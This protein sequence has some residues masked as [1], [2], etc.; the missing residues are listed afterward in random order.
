MTHAASGQDLF[1]HVTILENAM[2]GSPNIIDQLTSTDTDAIREGA[3]LAGGAGLKEAVPYLVGHIS[4]SNIGVQEAADRALR[5][6]GGSEVVLGVLP[7]LRSDDAPQR[8]IAMDILRGNG[9]ANLEA[10]TA[11]L[12]D[13]DA[14]IRIF[15]S[16]I[17]GSVASAEVVAPLG[18][19]LL[20]DPEVNVRYQ[21]AVSLGSL[22]SPEAATYLNKALK[23]D[24]WVQFSVI[25]ALTKIRAESSITAMIA[26]LDKS[27][28]LIGSTIVDAL[29]EMGNVKAVPLLLKRLENSSSAT[30]NKIVRAT[31]KIFKGKSLSVLGDQEMEKMRS[32]IED[33]ISDEDPDVQDAAVQGL[34]C[35]KGDNSSR[36]IMEL[37]ATINPDRHTER[38]L[39]MVETLI[40]IGY[41]DA[42]AEAANSDNLAQ[43]G[44]ALEALGRIED[45]R[46]VP[47]LK[48]EFWKSHRDLQRTIIGFLASQSGCEEQ[49]FFLDVINRHKDGIVLRSALA[50]LGHNGT[51]EQV[52]E[53]VLGLLSHPYNDVKE[54]AMDAC[55]LLSTPKIQEHFSTIIDDGDPLNRLMAVHTLGQIDYVRYMPFIE[56][57]L[58]DLEPIVRKAAVDAIGRVRPLSPDRLALLEGAMQDENR[59]VRMTAVDILGTSSAP[60]IDAI[61]IEGLN[62]PAPWVQVRCVNHLGTRKSP[63]ATEPLVRMLQNE[64]SLVVLGAIGALHNIG[65]AIALEALTALLD[66]QDPEI[67]EAAEQAVDAIRNNTGE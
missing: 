47:V 24:E 30:R 46:V 7:L 10:I 63:E 66:N 38:L 65:G 32:Y 25:E 67:R 40:R 53:L 3:R 52:D 29:G 48:K 50:F 1:V 59:E 6:I 39:F 34:A 61:L 2:P 60:H 36:L 20:H 21:A 16:D 15:A 44:V 26:A 37:A 13:E 17:L 12:H 23:D 28:A 14:D 55:I 4:S 42:L 56:K 57:S 58:Q 5:K 11:L 18:Q 35:L 22:G 45:P 54:A 41:T 51:P 8:N 31:I 64:N 27:T 9:S 33:A 62:D 19:A 49:D 43:R